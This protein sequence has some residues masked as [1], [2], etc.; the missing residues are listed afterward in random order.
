MAACAPLLGNRR[1]AR[2]L[3]RYRLDLTVGGAPEGR[4]RAGLTAW[5]HD[6]DGR[7]RPLRL[8]RS[9]K[10]APAGAPVAIAFVFDAPVN[11]ERFDLQVDL[12]LAD[13]RHLVRPLD[14]GSLF[15]RGPREPVWIAVGEEALVA[16][17]EGPPAE[18]PPPPP[19]PWGIE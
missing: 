18:E 7:I 11:P 4:L 14:P 17:V 5:A 3:E 2:G 8:E 9:E 10:V 12:G 1:P 15:A 13:G 6:A 16:P 19:R